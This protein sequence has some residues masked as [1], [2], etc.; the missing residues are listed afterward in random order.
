MINDIDLGLI[1]ELSS[2]S[3]ELMKRRYEDAVSSGA[4]MDQDV[5]AANGRI[6]IGLLMKHIVWCFLQ[7]IRWWP[8]LRFHFLGSSRCT[9]GKKLSGCRGWWI[10]YTTDKCWFSVS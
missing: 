3:G 4:T 10:R 9:F 1:I 2:S 5:D 6:H 8:M 7:L